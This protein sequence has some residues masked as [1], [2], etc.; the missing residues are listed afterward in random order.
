MS[1]DSSLGALPLL[2]QLGL[3]LMG[4]LVQVLVHTLH[5]EPLG[6]EKTAVLREEKAESIFT[7]IFR[8]STGYA[9]SHLFRDGKT[10]YL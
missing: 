3:D 7:S 4:E 2:G 8:L 9:Y 10:I 1:R 6:V 5:A